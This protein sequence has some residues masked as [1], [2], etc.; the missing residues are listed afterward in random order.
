MAMVLLLLLLYLSLRWKGLLLGAIL[1]HVLN[2]IWPRLFAPVA[3]V[4]LGFAKLF[5]AVVSKVLLSFVFLT[6][7]TPVGVLRRLIGRDALYL[8]SFKAGKDSAMLERNHKFTGADL[9]KPY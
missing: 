7:V 6:I 8:R 1:L 9:E 5:G 4:W 2:M 3:F